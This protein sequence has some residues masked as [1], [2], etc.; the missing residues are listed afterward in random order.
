MSVKITSGLY[1]VGAHEVFIKLNMACVL[2]VVCSPYLF[3]T[4][5]R[6]TLILF[7]QNTLL[8]GMS[9]TRI[10]IITITVNI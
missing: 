6:S 1:F 7:K 3:Y 5:K 9:L 10:I 2:K 8:T 4:K